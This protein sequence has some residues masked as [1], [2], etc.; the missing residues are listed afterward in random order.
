MPKTAIIVPTY[1]EAGNIERLMDALLALGLPG[2]VVVVDDHSPDGTWR[3]AEARAEADP[4]VLVVH[5]EAKL[6]LGTAYLAGFRR[7]MEDPEIQRLVTMD[8]DFSHPPAAIPAILAR[9]AEADLVIG[10]RYVPGGRTL[11][12]AWYRRLISRTAN[13]FARL[14]LGLAPNDCTAG[15]RCYRREVLEKIG[16]DGVASRGYSFLVEMLYRC[17]RSGYRVAE[18]PITYTARVHGLSKIS[19]AEIGGTGGTILRLW[20]ERITGG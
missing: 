1:N 15:F 13:G 16:P 18:V 6:G 19:L 4:R 9:S 10:S 2:Y 7:A 11:E 8:A 20:R 3:L 14:L 12:F 17:T 5:R